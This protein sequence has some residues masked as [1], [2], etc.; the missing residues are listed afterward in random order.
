M[1][2]QGFTFIEILL[3]LVIITVTAVPLMRL[4]S[5]AVEQTALVE[6]LRTALDLGREEVEKVKNLAL[7]EEQLK[8]MGNVISPPIVLNRSVWYTVRIVSQ[9]ETPPEI[10]VY[11][12][13]DNLEAQPIVSLVTIVSK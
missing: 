10:S 12:F 7:S 3:T 2:K 13:R 11:V 5:T 6:E 4:Y 8:Q 9:E 1:S